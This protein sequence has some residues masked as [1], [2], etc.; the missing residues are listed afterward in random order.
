M[1]ATMR[2]AGR[3]PA[4]G[5]VRSGGGAQIRVEWWS[6]EQRPESA[7]AEPWESELDARGVCIQTVG[8]FDE[9]VGLVTATPRS[10]PI[11]QPPESA[12]Q[13]SSP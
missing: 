2:E 13:R 11:L 1:P 4:A 3:T 12:L 6:I 8:R 5:R 9:S 10:D 7:A